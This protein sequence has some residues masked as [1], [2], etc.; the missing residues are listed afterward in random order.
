MLILYLIN[1]RLCL[2]I[3]N[4]WG[5]YY[6]LRYFFV[7]GRIGD[8]FTAL[9]AFTIIPFLFPSK[10]L[11]K[12]YIGNN[13]H[14]GQGVIIQGSGILKIGNS[15]FIG[16]YCVIGCNERISI[17]KDVMIASGVSIRDTDHKFEKRNIDLSKQGITTSPVMIGNGVW[18]GSNATITSGVTVGKG[19]IIGA[20]AVVTKNVKPY[21]IVG[22]VPAKFIKMR[23]SDIN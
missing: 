9:P 19:A 18:I 5:F 13:V 21:S 10:K 8:N 7:F 15:S 16:A 3:R 17:G 11:L 12:I 2:L 23:P 1:D 22:G 14:I 20:N 6:R 4:L